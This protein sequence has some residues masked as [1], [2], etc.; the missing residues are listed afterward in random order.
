[1]GENQANKILDDTS[2]VWQKDHLHVELTYDYL[3]VNANM[4]KVRSPKA[5]AI[6]MFAGKSIQLCEVYAKDV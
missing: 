2:M 1:M 3:N 6:V 5:G 4:D